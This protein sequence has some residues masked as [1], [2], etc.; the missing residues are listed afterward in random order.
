MDKVVCLLSFLIYFQF[1][2]KSP[3][4]F[5]CRKKYFMF[6]NDRTHKVWRITKTEPAVSDPAQH[7]GCRQMQLFYTGRRESAIKCVFKTQVIIFPEQYIT[8]MHPV[9]IHKRPISLNCAKMFFSIQDCSPTQR[10][11]FRKQRLYEVTKSA[12]YSNLDIISIWK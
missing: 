4:N 5:L 9:I 7:C 1:S 2:L 8:C 11:S 12:Q 6:T 3:L 10:Q